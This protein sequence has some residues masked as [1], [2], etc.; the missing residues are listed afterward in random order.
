MKRVKLQSLSSP[1][2]MTLLNENVSFRNFTTI[3]P[4]ISPSNSR[5]MNI[6]L[7]RLY[8]N[9]LGLFFANDISQSEYKLL[10]GNSPIDDFSPCK[11]YKSLRKSKSVCTSLNFRFAQTKN[12]IIAEDPEEAIL[13]RDRTPIEKAIQGIKGNEKVVIL[14]KPPNKT[15]IK[16]GTFE[17]EKVTIKKYTGKIKTY[18]LKKRFGFIKVDCEEKLEIFVCEDDLV[19][20]GVNIKQFKDRVCK[21]CVIQL[22]FNIKMHLIKEKKVQKA[23]EIEIMN[24]D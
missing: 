14:K 13:I 7:D 4:G 9:E 16:R 8:K 21:K 11:K 22:R 5:I 10:G 17:D 23:V 12:S 15:R 6:P 19:L 24:A 18:N 2:I 20:S 1:N 3:S